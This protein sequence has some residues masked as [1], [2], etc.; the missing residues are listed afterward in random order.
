MIFQ[1][2]GKLSKKYTDIV[3]LG[4]LM[5]TFNLFLEF[6][7][8]FNRKSFLQALTSNS[9]KELNVHAFLQVSFKSRGKHLS[10]YLFP[11]KKQADKRTKKEI[12]HPR[13]DGTLI[14]GKSIL[15][16]L[17]YPIF[18]KCLLCLDFLIERA[19]YMSDFIDSVCL[20]QDL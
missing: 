10:S 11:P 18:S 15:I 5:T 16:W 7:E 20:G 2:F 6:P 13:K 3:G 1:I 19:H 9:G 4:P 8:G 12:L 17:A 14:S